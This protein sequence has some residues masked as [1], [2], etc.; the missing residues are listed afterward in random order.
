M[1]VPAG[2]M[3]SLIARSI[4]VRPAGNLADGADGSVDHHG[5][6]GG[7]TE[8]TEIVGEPSA[9][10]HGKPQLAVIGYQ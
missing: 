9:V 7:E 8:R 10:V 2:A 1:S 4:L 3:T 6:A 5:V